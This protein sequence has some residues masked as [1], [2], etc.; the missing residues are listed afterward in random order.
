MSTLET[1]QQQEPSEEN[2]SRLGMLPWSVLSIV[3][4]ALDQWTKW[5]AE[6]YL[7][8]ST[9]KPVVPSF[10]LTLV[11]NEGAAFSFLSDQGGWQRWFFSIVSIFISGLLIVWLYRLKNNERWL[12]IALALLLGGALGNLYDRLLLGHVVDFISLYYEQYYFA[13]FNIADMAI[14]TGGIMIAVDLVREIRREHIAKKNSV[15]E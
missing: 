4:F 13:V 3:L 7:I 15:K 1:H 5:L 8:Y 2:R 14:T 6:T 11:Y 9:P 12:A 10:N